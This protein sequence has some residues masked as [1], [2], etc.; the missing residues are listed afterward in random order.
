[1][2]PGADKHTVAPLAS[3]VDIGKFPTHSSR[4]DRLPATVAVGSAQALSP[5][6][7][8]SSTGRRC[9]DTR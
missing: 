7:G 9:D 5:T 2:P 4:P 3:S 6:P 1:M 8:T